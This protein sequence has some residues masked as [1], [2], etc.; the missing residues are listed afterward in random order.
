MAD[1]TFP[2]KLESAYTNWEHGNYFDF[3]NDI[4]GIAGYWFTPLKVISS[5]IKTLDKLGDSY[6]GRG[7]MT[8]HPNI[9]PMPGDTTTNLY[10]ITMYH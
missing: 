1:P 4:V 2:V 6:E 9:A 5:G 10:G 7:S 8:I 3:S